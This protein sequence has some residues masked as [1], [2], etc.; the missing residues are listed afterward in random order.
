LCRLAGTHACAQ[1]PAGRSAAGPSG[2]ELGTRCDAV[3][4][5]PG[6]AGLVVLGQQ[7]MPGDVGQVAPDQIV[8]GAFDSLR[9]GT[10]PV[11]FGTTADE[12]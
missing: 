3:L 5:G 6:Q 8:L 10:H 4:D 9:G 2:V 11:L 12:T 1:L 7:R